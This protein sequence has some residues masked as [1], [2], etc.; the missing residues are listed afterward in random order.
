M[1]PFVLGELAAGNLRDRASTLVDLARLP[2]APIAAEAEVHHCL[3]SHRLSG[4]GLGWIDLHLL[5][6]AKISGS[7][8]YSVDSAMKAA[9]EKLKIG[10]AGP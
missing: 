3:E 2:S 5:A 6:S 10:R 9:A 4:T 7:S 8:L 1:H